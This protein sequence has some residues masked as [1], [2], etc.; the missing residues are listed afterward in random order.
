M[1]MCSCK[2]DAMII[3]MFALQKFVDYI[4]IA[5]GHYRLRFIS[6]HILFF[7]LTHVKNGDVCR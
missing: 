4:G 1:L 3:V 7:Y 2:D 5:L 6:P